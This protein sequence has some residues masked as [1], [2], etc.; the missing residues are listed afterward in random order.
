MALNKNYISAKTLLDTILEFVEMTP[1]LDDW[2]FEQQKENPPRLIRLQQIDVLLK[3]LIPEF[4]DEYTIKKKI[5]FIYQGEFIKCRAKERYQIVFDEMDEIL[6]SHKIKKH[7][8]FEW[9]IFYLKHNYCEAFEFKKDIRQMKKYN[10]GI[11]EIGYAYASANL[12]IDS[13]ASTINTDP[14]DHFLTSII[15]PLK[16]TFLKAD[17]VKNH[18]YPHADITEIDNEW[19]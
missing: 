5:L 14:A 1:E 9:N 13:I 7:K 17:L 6:G 10:K 4:P 19:V 15:D 8:D 12:L 18:G 16:Q 2:G 11:L 3:L